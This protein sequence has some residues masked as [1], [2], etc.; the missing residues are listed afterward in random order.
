MDTFE[1]TVAKLLDSTPN[2]R[3]AFCGAPKNTNQNANSRVKVK[4]SEVGDWTSTCLTK[5]ER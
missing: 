3:K 2:I 4:S 5:I 1:W